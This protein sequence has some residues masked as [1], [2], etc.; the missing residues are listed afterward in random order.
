MG[1]QN[2][3][4]IDVEVV[5]GNARVDRFGPGD[6]DCRHNQDATGVYAGQ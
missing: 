1:R 5:R 4:T 3:T 2:A 6:S